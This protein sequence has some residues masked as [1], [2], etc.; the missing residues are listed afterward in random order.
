MGLMGFCGA[1]LQD[2]DVGCESVEDKRLKKLTSGR[3]ARVKE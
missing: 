2:G 3:G 1:V